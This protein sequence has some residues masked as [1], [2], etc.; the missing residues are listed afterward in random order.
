MSIKY[1]RTSHL[2]WSLGAT[3]DDRIL[4]NITGFGGKRVIITKKMD[5]E[6]TTMDA[7]GIHARSLDSRGG[8]DRDWCKSLWASMAH[9]IPEK[10]RICGEN[11]WAQHSI[12][13]DDLPSFFM[14]FS[15]WNESNICL[16][17]DDTVQYLH[18]LGL[19][20]VHVMYDGDWN[21]SICKYLESQLDPEKDEGY[22]VRFADQFHYDDFGT[23]V[24]KF[25]RKGHVQTGNIHW[26][27]QLLVQNG[28]V[29]K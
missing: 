21:L 10:W 2:P 24:A 4:H 1:P 16:G 22:V 9:N 5:G 12:A 7:E 8:I 15:V 14:A 6:N 23:S 11:L 20:H 19:E 3:S 26:R 27:H 13:Y 28:L 17:W 18:M 29:D 25:V